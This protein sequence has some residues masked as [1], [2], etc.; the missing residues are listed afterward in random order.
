MPIPSRKSIDSSSVPPPSTRTVGVSG[1][2]LDLLEAGGIQQ[3]GDLAGMAER[4]HAG[5]SGLSAEMGQDYV[6][7]HGPPEHHQPLV[8]LESL[9]AHECCPPSGCERSP[10]VDEGSHRCVEEHDPELADDNI[11]GACAEAVGLGVGDDELGV[12]DASSPSPVARHLHGGFGQVGADRALDQAGCPER[13]RATAASDVQHRMVRLEPPASQQGVAEGHELAV[14]AIGTIDAVHGLAT[15]PC[16]EVLLVRSERN[17][18]VSAECRRIRL[19]PSPPKP[20]P[21]R[22]LKR[23][24]QTSTRPYVR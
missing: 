4:E 3:G 19:W 8:G 12:G 20:H 5:P 23:T 17:P 9:T 7:G 18:L 24:Y 21:T 22:R 16:L 11:E 13:G 2:A 15:V 10:K 6:L 1:V 14:V